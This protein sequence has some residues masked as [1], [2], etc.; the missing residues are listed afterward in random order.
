MVAP[1]CQPAHPP[2]HRINPTDSFRHPASA[3]WSPR[4]REGLRERPS[5]PRG[6]H[7]GLR[8]RLACST[9]SPPRIPHTSAPAVNRLLVPPRGRRRRLHRGGHAD[10]VADSQGST[11]AAGVNESSYADTICIRARGGVLF[12]W[13]AAAY[14]P[15]IAA[16]RRL[17]DRPRASQLTAG[18][19]HND[20]HS[21]PAPAGGRRC[22]Q[23]WSRIGGSRWLVWPDWSAEELFSREVP[24]LGSNM[25]CENLLQLPSYCPLLSKER[26]GCSPWTEVTGK[27]TRTVS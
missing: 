23:S 14:S 9:R 5:C 21:M 3:G 19:P 24:L 15:E 13:V 10:L 6:A 4:S 22:P 2:S 18:P 1:P 20:V 26:P 11:P 17:Y 25:F 7:E 27:L 8:V 12:F 16:T